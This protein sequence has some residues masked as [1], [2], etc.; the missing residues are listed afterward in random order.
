MG[1]RQNVP[2]MKPYMPRVKQEQGHPAPSCAIPQEKDVPPLCVSFHTAVCPPCLLWYGWPDEEWV[3]SP[4]APGHWANA[5]LKCVGRDRKVR[6]SFRRLNL[7]GDSKCPQ[8][9][10][11]D[12]F[13][14]ENGVRCVENISLTHQQSMKC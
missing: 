6:G 1:Q 5:A 9:N 4:P 13:R 2:L 7:T 14:A 10:G 3:M 12:T 8:G 11:G